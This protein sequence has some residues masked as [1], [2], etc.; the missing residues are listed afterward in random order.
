ME[1]I[2]DEMLEKIKNELKTRIGKTYSIFDLC[3][4]CND[5]GLNTQM[6]DEEI[7]LNNCM[8]WEDFTSSIAYYLKIKDN[9]LY[10]YYMNDYFEGAINIV[11]EKVNKDEDINSKDFFS[12]ESEW[13]IKEI[14]IL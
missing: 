5:L 3:Y 2:I 10:D 14:E 6:N 4:L 7:E 11:L 1:I 12:L 13:I 9:E 8:D